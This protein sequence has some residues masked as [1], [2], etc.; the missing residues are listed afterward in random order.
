MTSLATPFVVEYD[1]KKNQWSWFFEV[2][3]DGLGST[4]YVDNSRP[5]LLNKTWHDM[6]W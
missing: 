1:L 4:L 3:H 2:Q 5:L 6:I